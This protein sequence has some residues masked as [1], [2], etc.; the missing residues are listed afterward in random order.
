MS[1]ETTTHIGC[2]VLNTIAGRYA[3]GLQSEVERWISK[4][5]AE[6]T[7]DRLKAIWNASLHLR[8]GDA[9][10]ARKVYQEHSIAYHR[11][12]LVPKGPWGRPVSEFQQAQRPS[13]MKRWAAVMRFYT[14]LRLTRPTERQVRKA[15]STIASPRKEPQFALLKRE[16]AENRI[17]RSWVYLCNRNRRK[18]NGVIRGH[19]RSNGGRGEYERFEPHPYGIDV[20]SGTSYYWSESRVPRYLRKLPYG[21]MVHSWLSNEISFGRTQDLPNG[22]D[23]FLRT[24]DFGMM[25]KGRYPGRVQILQEQGCKARIVFQPTAR[26]QYLAYPYHRFLADLNRELFPR[27]SCAENQLKGVYMALDLLESG[28]DVYSVDL[29]AATDRF[30][31]AVS[32]ALLR[33]LGPAL[34]DY[35]QLL[36]QL[37]YEPAFFKE[38]ES[39]EIRYAV[40][41]PMGLYGS[42]PLFHLSNMAVAQAAVDLENERGNKNLISF[43]DGSYFKVLGDDIVISDPKVAGLYRDFMVA[44]G[45]D[46]SENKSFQGKVAEFAGFVMVPDKRGRYHAFR[47]YKV[48]DSNQI[49]N[50]VEFLH[51]MGSKVRNISPYWD[52]M[53]TAYSKTTGD[54]DLALS[55][56]VPE[57]APPVRADSVSSRWINSLANIWFAIEEDTE[58]GINQDELERPEIVFPEDDRDRA[59]NPSEYVISDYQRKRAERYKAH[60]LRRDPL[61]K[62][63]LVEDEL[64]R[65]ASQADVAKRKTPNR[66]KRKSK[67]NSVARR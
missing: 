38:G 67:T 27:E 3:K 43:R 17:Q 49:T 21:H 26:V 30:P 40:G 52:K 15:L 47:P 29:S 57:E 34:R 39:Q 33:E 62:K 59:F 25:P 45:V 55:P 13:V 6:W 28:H 58:L 4:N 53:W 65:Q 63:V 18:I 44:L 5:G 50:P 14:S 11:G 56:L 1:V 10:S 20:L 60:S 42:F 37:V 48:P 22:L 16:G 61:L 32:Q 12:S 36:S 64:A 66:T 41:Q 54:R 23:N 9:E 2:L 19:F 31:R 7:V 51:S 35:S 8:N 46:I 24:S